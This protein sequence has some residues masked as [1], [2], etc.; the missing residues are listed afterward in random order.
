MR[1]YRFNKEIC[2]D[3]VDFVVAGLQ[4]AATIPFLGIETLEKFIKSQKATRFFIDNKG[5]NNLIPGE[6]SVYLWLDTGLVNAYGQPLFISLLRREDEYRGHFYGPAPLLLKSAAEYFKQN[7]KEIL[8][9]IKTFP[10]KYERKIAEREWKHIGNER[11]FLLHYNDETVPQSVFASQ[12]SE[13]RNLLPDEPEEDLVEAPEIIEIETTEE[14]P[15]ATWSA[16]EKELTL[17]ILLEKIDEMQNYIKELL[18]TIEELS[19]SSNAKIEELQRKNVEYN[20]ALMQIRSFVA[21]EETT[22]KAREA[23][24]PPKSVPGHDLIARKGIVLVLGDTQIR[25]NDMM[26]IIKD[27]GFLKGDFEIQ[28]DYSRVVSFSRR[29]QNEGRYCAIIFGACP[30]KVKDSASYSSIIEQYKNNEFGPIGIDA[31]TVAGGLKVTKDSFK[32]A[33]EEM[34]RKLGE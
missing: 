27:Y 9:K 24:T 12:L 25:T 26:G 13:L 7:R 4:Q 21:A 34:M 11:E 17:S 1:E 8:E 19:T 2:I 3:D 32:R 15:L 5:N 14:D 20:A 18:A 28:T 31:R 23:E 6:D 16:E 33:I 22:A 10:K 29:I 30:H